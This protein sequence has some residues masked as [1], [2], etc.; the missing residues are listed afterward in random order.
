MIC[1]KLLKVPNIL[2]SEGFPKVFLGRH[3]TDY[4]PERLKEIYKKTNLK[5]LSGFRSRSQDNLPTTL[6]YFQ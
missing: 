4:S 5:V 2:F 3:Y 1:G 6:N